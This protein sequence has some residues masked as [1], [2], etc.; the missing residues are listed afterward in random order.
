MNGNDVIT[1]E[2]AIR[3]LNAASVHL[4]WEN[5]PDLSEVVDVALSQLRELVERIFKEA[6]Q[7]WDM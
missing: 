4:S 5:E 7:S 3:A 1:L 2:E 6:A